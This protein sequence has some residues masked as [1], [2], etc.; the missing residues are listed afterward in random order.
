MKSFNPYTDLEYRC[1]HCGRLG[2]EATTHDGYATGEY[3]CDN[4]ACPEYWE[5][6]EE[7]T[8]LLAL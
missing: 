3:Y 6:I 8:C 7:P 5:V 2:E 4:K 1:T